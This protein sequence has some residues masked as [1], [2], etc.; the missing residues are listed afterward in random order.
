MAR[1]APAPLRDRERDQRLE[2]STTPGPETSFLHGDLYERCRQV[3]AICAMCADRGP[4]VSDQVP[5]LAIADEVPFVSRALAYAREHGIRGPRA[6]QLLAVL[7]VPAMLREFVRFDWKAHPWPS[8]PVDALA[9]HPGAVGL[10]TLA[11]IDEDAAFCDQYLVGLR[12]RYRTDTA[13]AD[14]RMWRGAGFESEVAVPIFWPERLRPLRLAPPPQ[15]RVHLGPWLP[16]DGRNRARGLAGWWVLELVL[17]DAREGGP[18]TAVA[19]ERRGSGPDPFVLDLGDGLRAR[20]FA[21]QERAGLGPRGTLVTRPAIAR[22]GTSPIRLEVY[23]TRPIF[24]HPDLLEKAGFGHRSAER[25]G[26]PADVARDE[27]AWSAVTGPGGGPMSTHPWVAVPQGSGALDAAVQIGIGWLRAATDPTGLP[28][29]GGERPDV[30]VDAA[31]FSRAERTAFYDL[32]RRLCREAAEDARA[33][34]GVGDAGTALLLSTAVGRLGQ[35]ELGA[36]ERRLVARFHG[37]PNRGSLR[38]YV[39]GWLDTEIDLGRELHAARN[40]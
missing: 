24:G 20:L 37:A 22:G 28:A 18:G 8:I 26:R 32:L 27:F 1:H 39:R 38:G 25:F 30:Q 13:F 5:L 16:R 14:G 9:G 2:P 33:H 21:F 4:A 35:D 15:L 34:A 12:R 36:L 6:V 23:L 10:L 3:E 11:L 40:S 29:T 7:A 17:G 19:H 31:A